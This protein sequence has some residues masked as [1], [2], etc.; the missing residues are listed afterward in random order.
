[1]CPEALS[2][3]GATSAR[4]R[5]KITFCA[6]HIAT[7]HVTGK[8]LSMRRANMALNA[9]QHAARRLVLGHK[10]GDNTDDLI[11]ALRKRNRSDGLED[12]DGFDVVLVGDCLYWADLHRHATQYYS[13][14]NMDRIEVG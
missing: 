9:G 10:W 8:C 12:G 1:M 4:A 3:V 5:I 13:A 11:E 7:S 14:F 2:H 6:L